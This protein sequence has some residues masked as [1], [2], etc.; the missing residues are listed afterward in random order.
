MGAGQY[1]HHHSYR[2]G[3]L[4]PSILSTAECVDKA[5]VGAMGFHYLK[6]EFL[7]DEHGFIRGGDA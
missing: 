5:G 1:S 4:P 2:L 7:D 6:K 3:A